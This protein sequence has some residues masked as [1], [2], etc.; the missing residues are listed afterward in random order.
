MYNVTIMTVEYAIFTKID[1]LISIMKC[2]HSY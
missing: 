1:K 2:F